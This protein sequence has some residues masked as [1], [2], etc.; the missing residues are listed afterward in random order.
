MVIYW[1][2]EENGQA[3]G[4]IITRRQSANPTL[5]RIA[6]SFLTYL[7]WIPSSSSPDTNLRNKSTHVHTTHLSFLFSPFFTTD[8]LKSFF[9][10]SHPNSFQKDPAPTGPPSSSHD[11]IMFIKRSY[12]FVPLFY[13]LKIPLQKYPSSLRTIRITNTPVYNMLSTCTC[14][15]ECSFFFLQV[16]YI[17]ARKLV[18]EMDL[19]KPQHWPPF[20]EN[21]LLHSV[22]GTPTSRIW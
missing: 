13:H 5:D 16:S 14:T 11:H 10:T 12:W 2:K 7:W 21:K 15:K 9:N 8:R 6:L 4:A 18:D 1:Q 20:N 22:Q 3:S 19:H 17:Y